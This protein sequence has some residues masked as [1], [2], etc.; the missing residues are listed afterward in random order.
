MAE[1]LDR[2]VKD[3]KEEFVD[4]QR[5]QA[6]LLNAIVESYQGLGLYRESVE[7][8]AKV[9]SSHRNPGSAR[10]RHDRIDV[11]FGPVIR[12]YGTTRQGH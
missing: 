10:C 11:R 1:L 9:K 7:L 12:A 4:D 3:V 8:F 6:D 2:A 5:M